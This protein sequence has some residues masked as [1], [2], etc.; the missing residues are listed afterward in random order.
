[1][2]KKERNWLYFLIALF[3]VVNVVTFSTAIPWQ[4]WLLWDDP[5]PDQ[6]VNVS[7]E[8]YQI[9]FPANL[10]EIPVDQYIRFVATSAD[11][12]YGFGVFRA[13]N[14]MVFQM[15]VLP[16]R[17]N[18]IIWKFDEPGSYSVR[19]TEYSGPQHSKMYYPDAILVSQ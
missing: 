4:G 18:E 7:F 14:S 3:V 15:Q 2:E 12:T 8:D 6:T 11:V 19:S 9:T 10:V 1:M 13:D 17:E 16:G 5:V